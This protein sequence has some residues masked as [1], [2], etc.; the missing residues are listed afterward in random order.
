MALTARQ[1]AIQVL[2]RVEEDGAYSHIALAAALVASNLDERDRGLATEL[3]YGTLAHQRTIDTVLGPFLKRPLDR[4]D[5]PV[6]LALR[7][8]LYQ[9]IYLDRIPAHA[10]V[11]EAVTMTKEEVG[12]GAS[13][14]VNGVLRTMLR[15][16]KEW[17]PF[18]PADRARRPERYLGQRYSL[19][20][21]IAQRLVHLEGLERAEALAE[22]FNRRPPLYLRALRPDESVLP[23]GIEM[24]PHIPGALRAAG[25]SDA[26][27]KGLEEFRWVVQDLGSQLIA[28]YTEPPTKGHGELTYI[29]DGCAGLGGKT[30]HLATATDESTLIDAVEPMATKLGMLEDVLSHTPHRDRVTLHVATLQDFLATRDTLYDRVLIDAPCTGLG[31]L[32]RHPETR[33]RRTQADIDSLVELQRELL[34]AAAKRV[35]PGGVLVYSVCTFIAEEGPGQI[36]QFLN[37]H[38]N[39]Q[40]WKPTSSPLDW[41]PYTDKSGDLRLTP[42]DHDSD[43]FYAARLVRSQDKTS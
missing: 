30:L 13:G 41:S 34:D 17:K 7:L 43:A 1:L 6:R 8:A 28:H 29:L 2:R 20:D 14:F 27:R 35:R 36:S 31:V 42:L 15:R 10:I 11:D 39:F 16:R 5:T 9:L 23:E 22:S 18:E 12:R 40:R 21:W 25:F 38:A 32:R 33:W 37:K 4:L 19:P 26:V 3:V 24:V